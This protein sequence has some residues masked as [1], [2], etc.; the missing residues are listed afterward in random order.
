MVVYTINR[1][2]GI[3]EAMAAKTLRDILN[4]KIPLDD[5]KSI[6]APRDGPQ[7][8]NSI[9]KQ[10]GSRTIDTGKSQQMYIQMKKTQKVKQFY[11]D[12]PA[13]S[14][15][16]K[17]LFDQGFDHH[18]LK[19]CINAFLN[20]EVTYYDLKFILKN[21][22]QLDPEDLKDVVQN[23][24]TRMQNPLNLE[25]SPTVMDL[26]LKLKDPDPELISILKTY[27]FK[28][29]AEWVMQYI[30]KK[31]WLYLKTK[32]ESYNIED[33]LQIVDT[34]NNIRMTPFYILVTQN[35][36]SNILKYMV[37][38]LCKLKDAE[39]CIL[40]DNTPLEITQLLNNICMEY[41]MTNKKKWLEI[42][43]ILFRI[44]KSLKRTY[45]TSTTA[46]PYTGLVE[47]NI[48]ILDAVIK[49]AMKIHD[50]LGSNNHDEL[51]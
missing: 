27:N 48:S 9:I 24:C 3:V 32:T 16:L 10:T 17:L 2:F 42:S 36:M 6:I 11:A 22:T 18:N 44:Y 19:E 29:T 41:Y 13:T 1:V 35:N 43:D 50:I 8:I 14:N 39:K 38:P 15:D 47:Q 4:E 5:F 40:P 21:A 28:S 46:T 25:E 12:N 31:Q 45:H 20:H 37:F 7:N 23:I 33:W 49:T 51:Y 34:I 30:E 26:A